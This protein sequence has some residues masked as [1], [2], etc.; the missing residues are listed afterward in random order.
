[1][2]IRSRLPFLQDPVSSQYTAKM[3][4]NFDNNSYDLIWETIRMCSPAC[5][6]K[7]YIKRGGIGG[8]REEF[9]QFLL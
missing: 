2:N 6:E 7:I 3:A 8:E 1:L 4:T 9:R 5:S